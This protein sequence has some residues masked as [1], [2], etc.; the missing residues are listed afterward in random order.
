MHCSTRCCMKNPCDGCRHQVTTSP[1]PGS[2]R[3]LETRPNSMPSRRRSLPVQGWHARTP[4]LTLG[5][6]GMLIFRRDRGGSS[7]LRPWAERRGISTRAS[8]TRR[9]YWRGLPDAPDRTCSASGKQSPRSERSKTSQRVQSSQVRSSPWGRCFWGWCRS[10]LPAAS[11]GTGALV[12][13][14]RGCAREPLVGVMRRCH[15]E[16]P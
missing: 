12:Q 4:G 15:C 6:V 14:G 13:V 2:T 7:F 1:P 3:P 8:L 10:S 11:G 5:G 9:T 16:F